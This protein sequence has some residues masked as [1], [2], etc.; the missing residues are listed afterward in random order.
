MSKAPGSQVPRA[1]TNVHEKLVLPV[2]EETLQISRRVVDT[3]R[4]LRVRKLVNEISV[5]VDEPLTSEFVDTERVAVGRILR[6]P[7]G[8]RHEGDVTIVPIIEE[9]LVVH[10]EL[11]LVEEVR[12]T[13][14]REVRKAPQQVTVRREVAVIERFD[15]VTQQWSATDE[16][17]IQ[18][19]YAPGPEASK[20]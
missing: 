11:V 5:N 14:R 19:G 7:I 4:I 12:I 6:A 17:D 8:I 3:G 13:R 10:K 20:T 2:M 1:D 9:R 18:N 15:P 16:G